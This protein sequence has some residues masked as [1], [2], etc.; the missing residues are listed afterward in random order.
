MTPG[1]SAGRFKQPQALA[2]GV[3][4][5]RCQ[6]ADLARRQSTASVE[7]YFDHPLACRPAVRTT[8]MDVRS[9]GWFIGERRWN[10]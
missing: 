5:P 8:D 1:N 7:G 3:F 10:L 6:S 2:C 4:R 9:V